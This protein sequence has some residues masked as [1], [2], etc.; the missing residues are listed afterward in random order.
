MADEIEFGEDLRSD[1]LANSKKCQCQ[2]F[3]DP[4]AEWFVRHSVAK[5]TIRRK[6]STIRR[7]ISTIWRESLTIRR[8]ISTI[9]SQNQP[10]GVPTPFGE[11]PYAIR[12]K[13]FKPSVFTRLLASTIRQVAST[14]RRKR[15][16]FQQ[17][18]TG[19]PNDHNFPC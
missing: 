17:A 14:I 9:R 11:T 13:D 18:R 12:R 6:S 1:H 8:A 7:A 4:S 15:K 2:P 19:A 3:G 16:L 10:F 5:S